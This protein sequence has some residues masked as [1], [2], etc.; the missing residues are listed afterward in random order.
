MLRF[1]AREGP[2]GLL[3]PT[4]AGGLPIHHAIR[5]IDR[6]F[7]KIQFLAEECPQSLQVRDRDGLY[8]LHAVLG[9][10]PLDL[11][12][13]LARGWPE[14][15]LERDRFGRLPVQIAAADAAVQLDTAYL[16]LRMCPQ[17]L[18]RR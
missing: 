18:L 2:R 1:V 16:L 9:W 10:A 5:S 14:A 3:V 6:R 12:Q 7:E 15:L 8:P 13:V 11:V 17:A 4:K